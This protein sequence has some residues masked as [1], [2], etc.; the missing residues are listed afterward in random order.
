MRRR[1]IN[2]AIGRPEEEVTGKVFLNQ[3]DLTANLP[4]KL[5]RHTLTIVLTITGGAPWIGCTS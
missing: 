5:F 4:G 1:S 2:L 3:E